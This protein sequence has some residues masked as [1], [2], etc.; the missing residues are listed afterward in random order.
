M[1]GRRI[2]PRLRENAPVH[3]YLPGPH[4]GVWNSAALGQSSEIILCEALIDALTFWNA[5]IRNVTASHG[6][7]GFTDE[8][9]TVFR[10]CGIKRVLI[11]YD[12]DQAGEIAAAKLAAKLQ[13]AG[14]GPFRVE[15]PRGMDANEYALKVT[16]AA[17]SLTL[18]IRK[19]RWLGKGPAPSVAVP[20]EIAAALDE[21]IFPNAETP[22]AE[23][24]AVQPEPHASLAAEIAA[25]PTANPEPPTTTPTEVKPEE[26]VITF[27]DRRYR[28]RGL[29]KNLSYEHL[30]VNLLVARAST[31]DAA[32]QSEAL[33]VDT[34]DLYS[35]QSR[36][37]FV[38]QA[39]LELALKEDAIKKDLGKI[40]LAL[41]ERQERQIKETLEPKQ[42]SVTLTEAERAAALDLLRS[43]DL[44]GRILADFERC[45]VVGE[46]TNKL[47]GYLAAVSRMLERPLAVVI[48]SSS[49]AGKSSLMEAILAF[50]PE[51]ARVKYSAMTGQ[52]LFYLGETDL[53][54]RILAIV[55]EEGAAQAAYALKLLQ[56]EGELTIASTGKDPAT[57]KLV[58]HEYRVEGPVMIFL[59][60][61]AIEIDEE[62]LNR[63]LVLTVNE[64]REQTRAIHRRQREEQTL[65]GLLGRRDSEKI[66]KL[67]RTRSGS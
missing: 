27:G 13:A 15:F 59:T 28:V 11:A 45:E 58:T 42:K 24:A 60:T 62:L 2:G 32:A 16:P 57:G 65:E 29:G 49:A 17:K 51:E 26:I 23:Q 64:E 43:P 35:A 39:A 48:Q 54:H 36:A 20:A 6:I 7:E 4:R 55:E 47:V 30:R 56:S 8:H 46:Q 67:H 34:L 3:L 19:A 50:M 14:I 12:R 1:Y 5:G 63:C 40:L 21:N 61:T 25:P 33:H 9:L 53:K 18:L 37:K 22:N 31:P 52:S 10:R 38:K 66:V 44:L 41:E